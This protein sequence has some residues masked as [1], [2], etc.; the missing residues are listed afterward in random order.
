MKNGHLEDREKITC[1]H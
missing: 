1:Q